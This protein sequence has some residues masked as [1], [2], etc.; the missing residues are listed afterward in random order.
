MKR[1]KIYLLLACVCYGY[2]VTAQNQPK[3]SNQGPTTTLGTP[4]SIP[5][6]SSGLK[7]NYT[8]VYEPATAVK[9]D[10]ELNAIKNDY[11]K[12][13]MQ[14]N[15]TDGLGGP[16]QT[17][18]RKPFNVAV[19]KD[20]VEHH[21]YDAFGREKQTL[22][23]FAKTEADPAKFGKFNP[24]VWT[25]LRSTY[26]ALGYS[27]EQFL[28]SEVDLEES[29]LSR[30]KSIKNE[31]N[32]WVGRGNGKTIVSKLNTTNI[33]KW[34]ISFTATLPVVSG[35]YA[36]GTLT[37][38]IMT[39]EDGY[40]LT[41][42]TDM[43]GKLI[44]KNDKGVQS[45]FV[46]DDLNRLRFEIP[47]KAIDA[48]AANGQVMTQQVADNLCTRH[49]YDE[50]GREIVLKKPGI[51]ETYYVYNRYDQIVFSQD[52]LRRDQ[53]KWIFNKYDP[54]GRTI[55]TGLM[56][57]EF[58]SELDPGN[59]NAVPIN[60]IYTREMLQNLV[61]YGSLVN[62]FLQY[63]FNSKIYKHS[64]YVHTFSNATVYVSYYFDSYDFSSV[65]FS[66][67][68]NFGAYDANQSNKVKGLL[69]GTKAL[70]SDNSGYVWSYNFYNSRSEL[71]QVKR[72]YPDAS[73]SITTTG[74]DV[75]GRM[76]SSQLVH[77]SYTIV[78]K[79]QYD[80]L[81]RIMYVHHRINGASSFTKIA[82]YNYDDIGRVSSKVL[83]NMSHPVNYEY[84]IRNWITGINKAY[85]NDKNLGYYFGMAI[86]YEKGYDKTYLNGR[87]AGI[88]WRNKGTSNELRSYGYEYDK[89]RMTLA[90]Y[91]Q[92]DDN[93]AS[94]DNDWSTK[95]KDF[96][97][98]VSYDNNGNI[99]AMKHMGIGPAK[100]KIVLDDLA[101]T[102][103]PNSNLIKKIVES[104][105]DSEAKDPEQHNGMGDFRD[106][107][108]NST[109]PED[110]TYDANG[111]ITHDE[112]RNANIITNSWFTINKPTYVEH[113]NGDHI[114]YIY[115][116]L[117]NLLQKKTFQYKGALPPA[118]HTFMYVNDL[119]YKNGS[120]QLITHDEGRVR[121]ESGVTG[122]TYAYDYFLKD[123]IDNVRSIITEDAGAASGTMQPPGTEP[124]YTIN[125]DPGGIPMEPGGTLP[126]KEPIAYLATSE[127]SNSEFENSVFENIESTRASRPLSTETTNKFCAKIYG[128]EEGQGIGPSIIL[129]VSADDEVQIGVET[130]FFS[131]GIPGNAMPLEALATGVVGLISGGAII[132][133]EGIAITPQGLPIS[134]SQT[135]TALAQIQD[136]QQDSTKP[137]AYLNYM[138]FDNGMQFLPD[139]S[140]A[141]QV[142]VSD[143][144]K[145]IDIEK[146]KVP[147]N[148]FLYIFTSNQTPASVYTDNLYVI[149][150][151]GRLLEETHYYPYGLSFDTYK[152]PNHKT[153]D[154]KYNCQCIEQNEYEDVNGDSYGLDWY[155]FAA[156]SYDPQIGRWMQPDPLMQHASPYL[157]MGDNPVSFVDPLGLS[158][159][160]PDEPIYDGGIPGVPVCQST[161]PP[162]VQRRNLDEMHR[163]LDGWGGS[164][165]QIQRGGPTP[166]TG[167]EKRNW[168]RYNDRLNGISHRSFNANKTYAAGNI[169]KPIREYK[170]Y[171]FSDKT[172]KDMSMFMLS[173]AIPYGG[174]LKGIGFGARFAY[175]GILAKFGNSVTKGVSVIGPRAIYRPFAKQIGANFLKVTD[176]AWTWAKNEKFLA[177]VVKRGDDVIFAGKYNPDLLDKASVLAKEI[178]YLERHGY[179]W[180]SDF[181]KMTLT[182]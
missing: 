78:K 40:T 59:P 140:G 81:D 48:A 49:E 72:T 84:N 108:N 13:A 67:T 98:N 169:N 176:D 163:A 14:T 168:D 60:T 32:N 44:M 95:F 47:Q 166:L 111:N 116:A 170:S 15:A 136:G 24:A 155:D 139:A 96:T 71:I 21:M 9:T 70:L 120:L 87:I 75:K 99:T 133:P 38:A 117:G 110:Y 107:I 62:P 35:N 46:Y 3:A 77:G 12:C 93:Q 55:Q 145:S 105:P 121:P 179:K 73:T 54:S 164:N 100:N 148:G 45:I 159:G 161:L 16:L 11:A 18:V 66:A 80:V 118:Q 165:G 153:N 20:M 64:D 129:K 7:I 82:Q 103:H 154:T 27:S 157:A 138:M 143:N 97:T 42:Y 2:I 41:T 128:E 8:K 22:L 174:I 178:Y 74:Y 180:T 52:P 171:G 172:N 160:G 86:Y 39:D 125:P 33:V 102:Y 53:D 137:K 135:G 126:T 123:Y 37:Q 19:K 36:A 109:A 150:W 122:T 30:I 17:V 131:N 158:D 6:L 113:L 90:D 23:P 175:I 106:N 152:A 50:D 182:K 101:Y 83:G 91:V 56:N 134:V 151:T 147:E 130:F 68:T 142:S 58:L 94:P 61:S 65:S 31:G 167:W 104:T 4:V 119:I 28:Y 34:T 181:I 88:Q 79:Y 149:T 63:V 26:T 57:D 112:N 92:Q 76:I 51:G 132:S 43:D 141:I 5:N 89:G 10:A 156:R 85:C 1:F 177:G 124:G 127:P 173:M 25:N 162:G 146:I 144:W 29:P 114:T 69:T 115:D